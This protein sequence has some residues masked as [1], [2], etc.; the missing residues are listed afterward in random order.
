MKTTTSK[1]NK[2]VLLHINE[3]GEAA[4]DLAVTTRK[5]EKFCLPGE[6][7]PFTGTVEVSSDTNP[8]HLNRRLTQRLNYKGGKRHGVCEEFYENGKFMLR[9][10]YR[11]G[12]RH[13]VC[14]E[15]YWNGILRSRYH[16][17]DGERH[18]VGEEFYENGRLSLRQH[19]R[20]GLPQS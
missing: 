6:K 9:E 20:Y 18:G 4:N 7:K 17:K 13:G 5:W 12:E 16:Y 1:H 11:D 3:Y 15:F 10:H 14:E 19:Y 2:T 8:F